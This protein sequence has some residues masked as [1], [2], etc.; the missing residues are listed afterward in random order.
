MTAHTGFVLATTT[1]AE[2]LK[3]VIPNYKIN[4]VVGDTREDGVLLR[5]DTLK[6]QKYESKLLEATKSFLVRLEPLV[7][8]NK[9]DNKSSRRSFHA[10]NEGRTRRKK[11][12][13]T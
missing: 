6:L 8:A 4:E 13:T 12:R 3:D 7:N 10:L 1:V 2:V 11:T 9:M 5:K